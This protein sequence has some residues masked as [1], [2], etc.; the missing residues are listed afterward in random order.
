[1][2]ILA[3]CGGPEHLKAAVYAGADAVYIGGPGFSARRNAVN[4][5]VPDIRGAARFCR[6]FGVKLY[7]AVNILVG[8]GEWDELQA[9]LLELA[10]AA[11]DALIIQDMGVARLCRE[12][13]PDMPLHASTQMSVH[14]PEGVRFCAEAGFS[15]VIVARE[16]CKECLAEIMKK[17]PG[18]GVEVFVHGALCV[19]LSGQCGL[20]AVIGGR[21]GNRGLCA[22]PCRLDFQGGGRRYALSLKDLCLIREIPLL[23]DMG[24]R[25]LKIEGRMKRPEYVAAAVSA[26]RA[27]LEGREPDIDILRAVFSRGGFTQ[28]Y[29]YNHHSGM[30]GVRAPE[31]VKETNAALP[32]LAE[33]TR[34]PSRRVPVDAVFETPGQCVLTLTDGADAVSVSGPA[35]QPFVTRAA[36]WDG[37]CRLLARMGDTPFTLENVSGSIDPNLF[38]PAS[39]INAMRR[40]A[41]EGLL[42]KRVA[43][44]TPEYAVTPLPEVK[45]KTPPESETA[46]FLRVHCRTPEQ[47]RA[48]AAYAGQVVLPLTQ[49]GTVSDADRLIAAPGRFIT[50]EARLYEQLKALKSEG[51][52]HILCDNPAHAVMGRELGFTLHGGLGLNVFNGWAAAFWAEYGFADLTASMELK[53]TDALSLCAD[54]PVGVAAYGRL[55]VMTLRR[56]PLGKTC[57]HGNCSLTDRTGRTFPINC[58]GDWRELLNADILWMADKL[59]KLRRAPFLSLLLSHETP[60]EAASAARA[61]TEGAPPPSKRT[62]GLLERGVR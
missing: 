54:I 48:V 55:P 9:Y 4:F 29:F 15:R 23:R 41:C 17:S 24:V 1:M 43:R 14:S 26:C 38:I 59:D 56:C 36:S 47:A 37:I 52:S 8:G 42:E 53:L 44:L 18:I 31:D 19:S 50:G 32:R 21:S 12:M 11:P 20:S 33:L 25:A 35:P 62:R 28:G 3:P 40:A 60:E 10:G 58:Y 46:P 45:P 22:Q 34:A 2:E 5:S 30:G 49:I 51:L 13:L 57:G 7:V 27:S 39:Q 16:C 6:G 61:H